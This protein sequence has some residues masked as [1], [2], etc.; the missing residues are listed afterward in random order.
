[1]VDSKGNGS[2]SDSGDW[3][4]LDRDRNLAADLLPDP[5]SGETRFF[6]QLDPMD[7]K[8]AEPLRVRV[9]WLVDGQWCLAAEDLIVTKK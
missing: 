9:E 3:L 6:L 7:W 2:L 8:G 4:G 5:T 1:M